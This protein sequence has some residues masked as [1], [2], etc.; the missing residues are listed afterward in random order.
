VTQ[1]RLARPPSSIVAHDGQGKGKTGK[2]ALPRPI[3]VL[4]GMHR[5]GTSLCSH[6]LSVLGVDMA[7]KLAGPGS[8]VISSD[9]AR[10]YWERWE[11]VGFHDR[12]LA[13]FNRGYFSPFHDLPLPAGWW[14]DPDVAAVRREIVGFLEKRMCETRFGFKD[15]RTIRLL[16]LWQQ[17]FDDLNLSPQFVLCLRNPAEVARSLSVREARDPDMGEY[18][19][20]I[21]MIDFFRYI[22]SSKYCIVEY[23]K[24]FDDPWMNI[25]K[26][27]N[28]LG[29]N[30]RQNRDELDLALSEII[31]PTLRHD[32]GS[33][34]HLA[35]ARSL[36]ELAA[37]AEDDPVARERIDQ[38]T[39]Q[40]R[41][42]QQFETPFQDAFVRASLVLET[43]RQAQAALAEHEAAVQARQE[44]A[45]E[46]LQSELM[47][48]RT[49]VTEAEH[50]RVSD[51]ASLEAEIAGLRR[52]VEER[53]LAA[54]VMQTE[55]KLLRDE[56][57]RLEAQIDGLRR[58]VASLK[59]EAEE[60]AAITASLRDGLAASRQVGRSLLAAVRAG[61]VQAPA[62]DQPIG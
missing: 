7:D 1:R 53:R 46:A 28:L 52:D 2:P 37:R 8:E 60:R 43:E 14:A 25:T 20:V 56:R 6:V 40:F 26:L 29:L 15:P 57:T 49:A 12:I 23:E 10:G 62:T 39:V 27:Q 13:H 48:A 31:D 33:K 19:W 61:S 54:G 21:H 41:D 34:A 44:A 50:L 11:I 16:P 45:I 47:A 51:L 58:N 59:R 35:L 32:R 4:L 3:V 42:F 55:L 38:I 18:R 9:N 30:L 36:Y 24:W 5:S 22:G 17:I